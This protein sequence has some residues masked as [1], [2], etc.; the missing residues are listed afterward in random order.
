MSVPI[1]NVGNLSMGMLSQ[2]NP[3]SAARNSKRAGNAEDTYATSQIIRERRITAPSTALRNV[4]QP[5]APSQLSQSSLQVAIERGKIIE[6]PSS[7][8]VLCLIL[9]ESGE[10]DFEPSM[11]S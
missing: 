2:L 8:D 11:L 5:M 4:F 10:F 1:S 7:G 9:V 3:H 6:V